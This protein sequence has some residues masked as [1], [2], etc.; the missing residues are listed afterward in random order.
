MKIKA[1]SFNHPKFWPQLYCPDNSEKNVLLTSKV[2]QIWCLTPFVMFSSHRKD[3]ALLLQ[4]RMSECRAVF[5]MCWANNVYFHMGTLQ[6]LHWHTKPVW[7]KCAT[8]LGEV[9]PRYCKFVRNVVIV[10][11]EVMCT[12]DAGYKN[13]RVWL[14]TE[15]KLY[16]MGCISSKKSLRVLVNEWALICLYYYHLL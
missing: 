6:S 16:P 4:C 12:I 13:C 3:I 15:K 14:N 2:R 7:A 1:V 5:S 10:C 9:M 8:A 11:L